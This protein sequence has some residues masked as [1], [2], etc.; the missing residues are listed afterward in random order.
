MRIRM[1]RDGRVF[2]GTP[3]QI[4]E[5]MQYIAFGQENRTLGEYIDW[6]VDQV[7]RL[8]SIDLKV[9][10]DTDEDKAAS[11][12]QAMMGSGLAEKM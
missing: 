8:E 3:K 2:Q 11:L 6:L 4:V 12:V 10:G 7:Q 1:L 5:A 9:E